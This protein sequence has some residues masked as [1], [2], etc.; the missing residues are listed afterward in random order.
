MMQAPCEGCTDRRLGCHAECER[1]AAFDAERKQL[2]AERI[3]RNDSYPVDNPEKLRSIRRKY[4][5]R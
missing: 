1:Y 3:L 4:R 5:R 2:Q